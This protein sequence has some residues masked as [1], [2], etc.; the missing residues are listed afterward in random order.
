MANDIKSGG[1]R[2]AQPFNARHL[3][4]VAFAEAGA[5]LSGEDPLSH[6]ARLSREDLD[7]EGKAV[8]RWQTQGRSEPAAGGAPE[9]WLDLQAQTELGMQ[10][11]RC[12]EPMRQAL[13]FER[14]LR[15]VRDEA[16]AE[17][18]DEELE[19]DVLVW[20]KDFDLQ[21]LVEDELLMELPVAPRH[22]VCPSTPPMQVQT[23]DFDAGEQEKPNPFAALKALK[24]NNGA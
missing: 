16:T 22:E 15:F 8:V 20:R 14:S 11:Q 9:I 7:G 1:K 5:S 23:H 21:A 18:L 24:K 19:D 6:Y 17:L 2:A 3:D 12:L 10:C 13:A 4:I